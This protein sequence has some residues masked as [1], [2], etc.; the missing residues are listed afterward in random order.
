MTDDTTNG[1]T[2]AE[3]ELERERTAESRSNP[4]RSD[5]GTPADDAET[6]GDTRTSA[7]SAP[8]GVGT[9]D[10]SL[11]EG[12]SRRSLVRYLHWALFAILILVVLVATFRFYFA[13]SNAVNELV[14]DR[15]RPLFQ[16][17]FNLAV[18]LAAGVG[19]SVLVR[20]MT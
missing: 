6:P 1:G 3:G 10:D 12:G 19:L 7:G 9:D 20:R 4:T 5:G 8:D 14:S 2:D 15:F 16:A 11:T 13:A 18:I 17:G